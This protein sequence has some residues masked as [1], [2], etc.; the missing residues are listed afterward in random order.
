MSDRPWLDDLIQ[1]ELDALVRRTPLSEEMLHTGLVHAPGAVATQLHYHDPYPIAMD[2]G[3]GA[4]VSD[5]DGNR[6][7]DMHLGFGTMVC[8]H[9]HPAIT[10][11]ISFRAARGVHFGTQTREAQALM[12][13][14]AERHLADQV[15]LTN[16]GTEATSLAI[17]MARAHTGRSKVIKVEGGYH[18]TTEPL[19]VSTHPALRE[20]GPA[21]T[22]HPVPWGGCHAAGSLADTV[23]VP[24]N[25]LEAAAAAIAAHRPACLI[26][27]PV[28][29]N[30][31]FVSALEGYLAGL[32]DLC[33]EAGTLLILDEVKTGCTVG[34]GGAARRLDLSADLICLG[35]GIGGGLPLGAVVGS[36]EPFNAVADGTAPHY[37]T[38]AGNPLSCA[39][40]HAALTKVLTRQAYEDMEFFTARVREDGERILAEHGI[41]AYIAGLGAKGTVVFTDG[42]PLRDYRD[43]ETRPDHTLGNLYWLSMM[44]QGVLLSPGQDEQWTI[45]ASHGAGEAGHLLAA[46]THFCRLVSTARD[47]SWPS[48]VS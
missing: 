35:K 31:S 18:G 42:A 46:L 15:Q 19:M 21:R 25:D 9:A 4:W 5:V 36:W 10:E 47:A 14:L 2:K 23:V 13:E 27:E 22:P 40:G 34:Y 6:Y 1:S 38:F 12:S 41:P 44:N 45:S 20:A 24:F 3:A 7:L 26:V 32:A 43:Y 33:A 16:S 17:R 39:A 29:L 8:G 28:M 37:S 30:V 48:P 11:A